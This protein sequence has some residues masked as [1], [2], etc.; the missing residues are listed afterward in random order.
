[1]ASVSEEWEWA[2]QE[3]DRVWLGCLTFVCLI[4]LSYPVGV[5]RPKSASLIGEAQKMGQKISSHHTSQRHSN[6][7][8]LLVE[9]FVCVNALRLKWCALKRVVVRVCVVLV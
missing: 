9:R 1:M 3:G 6:G 4:D 5:Y 8:L 7:E 2:G